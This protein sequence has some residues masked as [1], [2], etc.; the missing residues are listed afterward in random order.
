MNR[1]LLIIIFLGF[2]V[3]SFSQGGYLFVKK[4]IKKK[5]TYVE[6][7]RIML[8]LQDGLIVNGII[9]LLK[10]DT[11]Y[12]NGR[13]VPRPQVKAVLFN[14]KK[15]RFPADAKTLLIIGAGAALTTAGLTIDNRNSF[16]TALAAGLTIGYGPLIAKYLARGF[17]LSLQRKRFRIGRKYRLQVLDFHLPNKRGF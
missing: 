12:L 9:T 6:G 2:S 7:D 16:K 1:L 4:G 17:I 11:I 15:N 8:Q 13:P 14:V 3:C 5:R 10:N